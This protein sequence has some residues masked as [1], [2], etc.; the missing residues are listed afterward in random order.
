[1]VICA[2]IKKPLSLSAVREMMLSMAQETNLLCEKL[3]TQLDRSVYSHTVVREDGVQLVHRVEKCWNFN[4]SDTTIT[5]IG[6]INN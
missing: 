3:D 6:T 1:M 4:F 2:K 5:K